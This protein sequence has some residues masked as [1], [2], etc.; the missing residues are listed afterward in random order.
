MQKETISSG[1]AF[2]LIA[3]YIMGSSITTG[4]A[5]EAQNNSW[6]AILIA[7]TAAIPLVLF[8][9][10]LITS[11]PGKNLFEILEIILGKFFGRLMIALYTWYVLHLG[12]LVIN[13]FKFFVHTAALPETPTIVVSLLMTIL[14]IWLSRAGVEVMARSAKLMITIDYSVILAVFLLSLPQINPGYLLPILG[15]DMKPIL[16]AAFSAF[17]YPFAETI[18]LSIVV[19]SMEHKKDVRKSYISGYLIAG[20]IIIVLGTRNVVMMGV[21][22]NQVE[23]FPS[24]AAVSRIRVGDFIQRIEGAVDIVFQTMALFQYSIYLVAFTKGIAHLFK[25]ENY[26][27]IA[28]PAGLIMLCLDQILYKN[29]I[30]MREFYSKIYSYYAMPFQVI[31]PAIIFLVYLIRKRKGCFRIPSS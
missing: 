5:G 1:Q 26:K 29:L 13:N 12:A 17:S 22:V 20:L 9:I 7:M 23:Y 11:F 21:P 25:V 27:V 10:K 30:E 14:G 28:L 8:N 19:Y 2:S 6:A 4:I 31:F 15:S 16:S 18:I 3:M 24:Y